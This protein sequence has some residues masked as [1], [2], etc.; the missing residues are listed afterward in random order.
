M[1]DMR[2]RHHVAVQVEVGRRTRRA[3]PAS[4]RSTRGSCREDVP[5][6]RA[7]RDRARISSTCRRGSRA[8]WSCGGTSRRAEIA[9][10]CG[11]SISAASSPIG[12]V[13]STTSRPGTE[14]DPVDQVGRLG[15]DIDQ[16]GG[17]GGPGWRG[18]PAAR[19][20]G[21]ASAPDRTAANRDAGAHA[22]VRYGSLDCAIVGHPR[23]LAIYS[24]PN[25]RRAPRH[26]RTTRRSSRHLRL[27]WSRWPRSPRASQ[28]RQPTAAGRGQARGRAASL[29][30]P[31]GRLAPFKVTAY[32]AAGKVLPTPHVRVIGPPPGGRVRRRLGQGDTRP[33]RSTRRDGGVGANGDAGDAR[34]P[35]HGHLAGA[36]PARDHSRAGPALLGRHPRAH[37]QGLPSPTAASGRT[38][39]ATW[40]SSNPAVATVDRF[41]NVTGADARH[42]D[43]HRRGRGCDGEQRYT[44]AA[45][46]VAHDR[47]RHQGRARSAPAT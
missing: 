14:P 3:R 45:N 11:P 34:D 36:R 6:R 43:D 12:M 8:R 29:D 19:A 25:P 7:C 32:D 35:G 23:V 39:T 44:V 2:R 5:G 46:P 10:P 33:A 17:C 1:T 24:S 31:G 40:R 37:G 30:H 16:V 41:G 27:L 4:R 13:F 38:S 21:T 28:R 9:S 26:E 42:G 22:S 47:D 18:L 15:A 20:P